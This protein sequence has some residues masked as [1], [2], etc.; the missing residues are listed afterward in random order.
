MHRILFLPDIRPDTWLDSN[1]FGKLSSIFF[2]NSFN[3]YRLLQTL[4]KEWSSNLIN[5]YA[6]FFLALFEE[7]LN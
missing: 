4:N 1:I 3:N 5:F 7:E 2:K 6:K